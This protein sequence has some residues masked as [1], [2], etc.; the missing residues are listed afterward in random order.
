M[1][2]VMLKHIANIIREVR[3]HVQSKPEMLDTVERL[4]EAIKILERE[5]QKEASGISKRELI[6][7]IIK[8]LECIPYIKS[9]IDF[10]RQSK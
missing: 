1:K 10:T 6:T 3:L 9:I 4:D 8:G 2:K 5:Y 7:L